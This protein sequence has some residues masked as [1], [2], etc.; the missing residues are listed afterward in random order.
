M[1][2]QRK[3]R[4]IIS[5]KSS[6]LSDNQIKCTYIGSSC[7]DGNF[8]E[9]EGKTRKLQKKQVILP[10]QIEDTLK[11]IGLHD[12]S[13]SKNIQIRG[14]LNHLKDFKIGTY[15]KCCVCKTWYFLSDVKD[16]LVIPGKI[17]FS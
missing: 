9:A 11:L 12:T 8:S 15:V 13:H 14:I 16:V 6:N 1:A 2:P 7:N 5:V 17:S 4:N 3:P 10:D